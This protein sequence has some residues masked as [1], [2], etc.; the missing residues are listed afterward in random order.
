M[1]L[2]NVEHRTLNVQHPIMYSVNLKKAMQSKTILRDSIRLSCSTLIF[3]ALWS[4]PKGSSQAAI[5]LF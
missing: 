1:K 3:L 2:M 4:Q 5:R